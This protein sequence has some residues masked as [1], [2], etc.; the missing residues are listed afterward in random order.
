[1]GVLDDL[2]AGRVRA[3]LLAGSLLIAFGLDM[4]HTV[5]LLGIV[6]LAVTVHG[7]SSFRLPLLSAARLSAMLGGGAMTAA[8][9]IAALR[10]SDP[11]LVWS[12]AIVTTA[13]SA[14]LA[15]RLTGAAAPA[16]FQS[17]NAAYESEPRVIA[18]R[19]A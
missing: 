19:L 7:V 18:A 6:P 15:R 11:A 4:D 16:A 2:L 13:G 3:M 1:M 12:L 9:S 17:V 14:V 5:G 10:W 8:W